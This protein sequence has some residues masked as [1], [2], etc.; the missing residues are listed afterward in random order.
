MAEIDFMGGKLKQL[1]PRDGDHLRKLIL[2]VKYWFK[3]EVKA[4]KEVDFKSYV[5]ELVCLHT[6]ENQMRGLLD[7]RA[8]L[9]AVFRV[10]VDF[11]QIRYLW[12]DK[13][14]RSDV[15]SSLFLQSPLIVDP[16]D[17]WR[18]IANEVDWLPVRE[19]AA[20]ALDSLSR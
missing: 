16:E 14:T 7:L 10:L 3:T 8:C 19:A 6:W 2:L 18:N 17:P 20:K 11:G 13:Y 4:K 12:T 5:L 1:T 9:R 15:P